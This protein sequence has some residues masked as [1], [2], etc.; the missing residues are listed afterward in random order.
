AAERGGEARRIEVR[1][2]TLSPALHPAGD[3]S[4][5]IL[6]PAP[7][8]FDALMKSRRSHVQAAAEERIQPGAVVVCHP[9]RER[10]IWG[11]GGARGALRAAPPPDSSL[12]SE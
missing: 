11:L 10:G 4:A 7:A 5:R 12:R 6:R 3:D 2:E 9:E 8:G 1:S